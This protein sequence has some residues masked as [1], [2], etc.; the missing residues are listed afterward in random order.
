MPQYRIVDLSNE[1]I[2][3]YPI[4][5]DAPSPELAAQQALGVTLTRSGARR[6]LRARVYSQRD[7]ESMNMVRLYG[8]VADQVQLCAPSFC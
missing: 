5:V 3:P 7:G 8:L 1:T 2:D 4:I 6:N